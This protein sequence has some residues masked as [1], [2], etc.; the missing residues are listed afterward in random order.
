MF[1]FGVFLCWC[2][3]CRV[4]TTRSIWCK[5]HRQIRYWFRKMKSKREAQ[6]TDVNWTK[7]KKKTIHLPIKGKFI[8]NCH[9]IPV[10]DTLWRRKSSQTDHCRRR[11]SEF[12]KRDKWNYNSTRT[13]CVRFFV[14]SIITFFSFD[15]SFFVGYVVRV[16]FVFRIRFN[17]LRAHKWSLR[18]SSSLNVNSS[19]DF[20]VRLRLS[21]GA[22]FSLLLSLLKFHFHFIVSIVKIIS[23]S[24]FF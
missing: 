18:F 11:E 20:R 4:F 5:L 8:K 19:T 1:F 24:H 10:A 13:L 15:I 2:L 21:F 16:W 6:D 17:R 22:N 12:R 9:R 23:F 14:N 7:K 3:Q